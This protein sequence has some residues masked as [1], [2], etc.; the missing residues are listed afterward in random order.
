MNLSYADRIKLDTRLSER[1]I[2]LDP[3]GYFLIKIDIDRGELVVEHYVNMINEQGLAVDPESGEVL[4]CCS[5]QS[6]SPL[7]I[8]RARTAK[9][10][11]IQLTEGK[12]PNPITY[13]DHALY[14]GRELQK[15]EQALITNQGYTQD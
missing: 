6:R 12:G 2:C 1:F 5:I 14:M 9:E 10:L 4:S 13:L 3:K 8:Y 11:G 15:A 7:T